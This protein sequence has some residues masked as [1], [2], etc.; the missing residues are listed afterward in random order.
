MACSTL[1]EHFVKLGFEE[2]KEVIG[3]RESRSF[4]VESMVI[5]GAL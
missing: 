3:A 2:V 4:G 1:L 5:I